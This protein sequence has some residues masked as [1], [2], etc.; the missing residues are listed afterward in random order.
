MILA[1]AYLTGR[2]V[3]KLNLSSK[4]YQK[5][6]EFIFRNSYVHNFYLTGKF[7]LLFL[8]YI[9]GGL[10]VGLLQILVRPVLSL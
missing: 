3:L 7:E 5:A 6:Q 4:N 8:A 2:I 10:T 9:K 1:F